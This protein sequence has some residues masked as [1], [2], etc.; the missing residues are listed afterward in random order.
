MASAYPVHSLAVEAEALEEK[1]LAARRARDEERRRRWQTG[2]LV[3]AQ[4]STLAEQIAER[5]FRAKAEAKREQMYAER[6]RQVAVQV[7]AQRLEAERAA[8]AKQAQIRDEW[9]AQ[10]ELPKNNAPQA[11]EPVRVEACGL[12]AAQTLAGEGNNQTSR[13]Q[14]QRVQLRLWAEEA[15]RLKEADRQS[16]QE[17]EKRMAA[18]EKYVYERRAE[19]ED[20]ARVTAAR[21]AHRLGTEHLAA[22]AAQKAGL[23]VE[24]RRKQAAEAAEIERNLA[25]PLLTETTSVYDDGR[26]RKDH[27]K[28]FTP[29]QTRQIYR[30]NA[31]VEARNREKRV[32]ERDEE[33][34]FARDLE[35]V[36]AALEEAEFHKATLERAK[37]EAVK[38]DLDRQCSQQAANAQTA[39]TRA[40]GA[41]AHDHGLFAGFGQS[42]R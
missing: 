18:W 41:V 38:A 26:V 20:A 40:F 14:A 21:E 28:G 16:A 12:A 31:A 13:Q 33:A 7:E 32:E 15:T 10:S 5:E 25:D 17:E 22:A 37:L 8:K 4:A 3:G 27:F 23:E 1:R 39:K 2:K 24:R 36:A 42:C 9:L 35:D 30:E 6:R 29:A 34:K 19:V 11:C